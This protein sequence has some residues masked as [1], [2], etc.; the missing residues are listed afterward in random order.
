MFYSET[1]PKSLSAPARARELL[2]RLQAELSPELLDDARLLLSEIVANAVEH[3]REDGDIEVRIHLRDDVLRVEVS[4]PGSGFVYRPRR[5]GAGL[6]SGWGL[7]F[8]ELLADR[9]GADRE[10]R[11]R[12]WFELVRHKER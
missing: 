12:V 8:T 9:W 11:A 1:L 10:G 7:H 2:E 3:V 4:D 5:A 6:G